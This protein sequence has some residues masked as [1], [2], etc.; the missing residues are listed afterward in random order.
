MEIHILDVGCGSMNLIIT[1]DNKVIFFDCNITNEN[2]KDILAYVDKAI[3]KNTK[4]DVFINSHRD[5]DHF[6]GIRELHKQH[7]ILKIEDNGV[8]GTTTDS[9][10][11]LDYMSLRREVNNSVE[12]PQTFIDYGNAKFR[13]MNSYWDDYTDIHDQSI[14][15]KIEYKGSSVMLTGDSSF[16]PWKEK[17]LPF[18]TNTKLESSILIASHHGSITFFDDPSDTKHYYTEHIK[19]IKPE[20]TL[21]SVGPNP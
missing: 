18:Y 16:R 13:Y 6:R 20:M 17:I 15:L 11:Y 19:K 9:S 1:P 12:K 14:V 2:K 3:G 21:V 4:I 8:P 10:E 7:N 5:S